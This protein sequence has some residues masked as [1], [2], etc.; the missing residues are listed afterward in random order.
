[1]W[2]FDLDNT[3][4]PPS[5]GLLAAVDDNIARYIARRTG[6]NIEES[7]A[8]RRRLWQTWG[9]T[10]RGLVEE[11]GWS[12]DDYYSSIYVENVQ[13][14]LQEDARLRSVLDSVPVSKAVFTNARPAHA[15]RVL[16]TLGIR[17]CF[18]FVVALPDNLVGKPDPRSFMRLRERIG[19]ELE[20]CIL[21]DDSIAA[22]DEAAR[23]AMITVYVG[24]KPD[25]VSDYEIASIDDLGRIVPEL[26]KRTD[27]GV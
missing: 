10:A 15:E 19:R 18:E 6:M 2:I 25:V 22:L 17:E 26:I 5:R 1:M 7:H 24:T 16:G 21:F 12:P 4:Y 8:L 23:H 9:T 3:L 14:F 11:F 27:S 20:N 13:D